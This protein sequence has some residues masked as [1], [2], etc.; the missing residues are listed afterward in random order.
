M[1]DTY[2]GVIGVMG[3]TYRL[4]IGVMGELCITFISRLDCVF[5]TS[6]ALS[7]LS[8]ALATLPCQPH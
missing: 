8:S 7:A 1:G 2:S 3:D 5:L 6:F 4:S